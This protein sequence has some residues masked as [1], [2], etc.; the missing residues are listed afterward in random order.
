MRADENKVELFAFLANFIVHTPTEKQITTTHHNKVLCLQPR[1]TSGLA[2]CTHEEADIRIF[3]HIADAVKHGAKSVSIRT[4]DSDNVVL[5]VS[6]ASKLKVD[7]LWV[8][9]GT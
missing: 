5:T 2:A 1:N 8:V 3:L 6:A 4:L 9:F 7:K